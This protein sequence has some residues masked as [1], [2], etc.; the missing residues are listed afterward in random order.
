MILKWSATLFRLPS[1]LEVQRY[2]T[3]LSSPWK[4]LYPEDVWWPVSDAPNYWVSV[5]NNDP[6][7]RLG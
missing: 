3:S 6:A 5:G 1:T 4:P 2:L 7:T